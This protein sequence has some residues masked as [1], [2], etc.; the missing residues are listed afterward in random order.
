MSCDDALKFQ[1]LWNKNRGGGGG[2]GSVENLSNTN[3]T[4]CVSA[5]LWGGGV[6]DTPEYANTQI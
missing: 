4:V 3:M 1:K 2:G 6:Y 5:W